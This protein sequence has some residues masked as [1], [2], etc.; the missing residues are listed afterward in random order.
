M[1]ERDSIPLIDPVSL[2]TTTFEFA[3]VPAIAPVKNAASESIVDPA[4]VT[5]DKSPTLVI[6]G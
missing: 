3:A 5:E 2:R 4:I 6:L 1:A